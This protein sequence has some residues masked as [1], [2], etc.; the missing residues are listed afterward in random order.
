MS[1]FLYISRALEYATDSLATSPNA[2]LSFSPSFRRKEGVLLIVSG[3]ALVL[4]SHGLIQGFSP[5]LL[6]RFDFLVMSSSTSL[7]TGPK[8]NISTHP[9]LLSKLTQLR[10]HDLPT[11]DFREGINGIGWVSPQLVDFLPDSLSR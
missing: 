9:L 4:T 5:L 8:L 1:I 7:P 6:T 3:R 10:L 11:K 2:T